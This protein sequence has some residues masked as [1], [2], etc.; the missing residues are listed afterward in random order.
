MQELIEEIN[1]KKSAIKGND[2]S[3]L[4]TFFESDTGL[5]FLNLLCEDIEMIKQQSVVYALDI[6]E[7]SP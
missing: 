6:H 2:K 5:K 3:I 7:S 4:S 1:T